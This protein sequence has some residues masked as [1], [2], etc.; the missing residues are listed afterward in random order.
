MSL[1]PG[2]AIGSYRL[3]EKLT[4]GGMATLH[5]AEDTDS[6]ERV[7]LKVLKDDLVRD[8]AILKR[9][10]REARYASALEHPNIVRVVDSG[11]EQGVH[12]IAMQYVRGRDL[13]EMLAREGPLAPSEA[14][15]ILG[16][17]AEA[18]DAAHAAGLIHRDVKPGNILIA[19]GEGPEP[20]GQC[21]LTDFGLSKDPGRDSTALT[22]GG[23]FVG[24][25]LYSAPEQMLGRSVDG[26]ADV[27]SLGCVLFQCLVGQPPFSGER[28]TDL[29]QAHLEA[30]PPKPSKA[31]P[32][33]PTTFDRVTARALAK[34]PDDRMASCGELLAEARAAFG[35]AAAPLRPVRVGNLRL[36]VVG[37]VAAGEEIVVA[38]ELEL[39]RE[40]EGDG[41]LGG[42]IEISRRHARFARAGDGPWTIEDL[43]STNGTF[44]EGERVEGAP[45][46]LRQ[47]DT[48]E[49]GGTRLVVSFDAAEPR[50]GRR[51]ALRL[52]VDVEAGE[53]R[54]Q[55]DGTSEPFRLVHE[56]GDWRPA[57]S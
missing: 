42:D 27:Y 39:G 7:V 9:F 31:N 2:R 52:E 5:V 37:G 49:V 35:I 18:L 51:L 22:V 45:R 23:Q 19:S 4:E 6:G 44:V 14:L 8:K 47:G 21:F 10:V 15:A 28:P 48:I 50:P 13:K 32:E 41:S 1:E 26:R 36:K 54:V 46:S 17:V 11:D 25:V 24:T 12:W 56:E 57:G 40:A 16:Q 34:E 55:P 3:G 20:A 30:T 53:V 43:G 38:S 33:L 29:M